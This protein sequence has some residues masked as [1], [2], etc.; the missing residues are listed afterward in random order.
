[1]KLSSPLGLVG[2]HHYIH[3]PCRCMDLHF[4]ISA[5]EREDDVEQLLVMTLG[6]GIVAIGHGEEIGLEEAEHLVEVLIV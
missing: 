6:V 4:D 2:F 1:M 3:T 5:E